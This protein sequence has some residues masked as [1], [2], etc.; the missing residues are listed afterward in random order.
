MTIAERLD[1]LPLTSLHVSIL[2][3]CTIGLSSDI[4][5]I[6]LSSALAA[7]FIAPPYQ[8]PQ[9]QLSLL[10]AAVFA[11]GALGAPIFGW[12]AD[13]W[14]GRRVLLQVALALLCGSSICASLS[15][16]LRSMI[17]FRFISGLALGAYPPLTS[18]YLAELLPPRWRG[19]V[20]MICVALA[21]LAA[22]AVIFMMR[23]LYHVLPFGSEAWRW[24]LASGAMVAAASALMLSVVPESPRWLVAAGRAAAAERACRRF[25]RS[26]GIPAP[27]EPVEIEPAFREPIK[28]L[29][30]LVANQIHR[31]RL[32]L[33]CS[34]YIFAPWSTYGF[35]LLSVPV[36]VQKGFQANDSLL[37]AGASMMGPTIGIILTALVI[38]L[39]SSG[40]SRLKSWI[41]VF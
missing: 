8:V 33:L 21:F 36:L 32:L 3:L 14:C 26:A 35:L 18:T 37:F 28:G 12:V 34:I 38:D 25:E 19:S 6:A 20:L 1:R 17:F 16:D 9:N 40:L 2:I 41:E 11:G 5:E 39:V 7:V 31:Y 29:R 30:L 23:G 22:P 13:R 4:A 10:L 15:P 24:A 27:S